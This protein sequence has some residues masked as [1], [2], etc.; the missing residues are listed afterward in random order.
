V[1]TRPTEAI[2]A[3]VT[4]ATGAAILALHQRTI[5]Q[6]TLTSAW[7]WSWAALAGW[8]GVELLAAW[9]SDLTALAL[10]P[11]RL[12]AVALSFCPAV[13]L[14]GAKRPQHA[15]WNIVVVSLWGIVALPAA[16]NYFLHPGQRLALGD[17]RGWFLWILILLGPI[18]FLPTRFWLA[19]L[20]VAVGQVVALSRYVA[21]PQ[22]PPVPQPELVGL[23][24]CGLGMLSAAA[25]AR[26]KTIAANP[27]DRLW[28]D[29][30]NSFGLFWSLRVQERM[31]AASAQH[32]WDVELG[33][34]GFRRREEAL[35]PEAQAKEPSDSPSLALQS[36]EPA[37]RT[38]F[39]GLLRRFVSGEW[40]AERM[41]QSLD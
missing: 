12:A 1:P 27:L 15:A 16:E 18:N 8:A 23:A 29:F 32:G 2:V 6:T 17:A 3:A 21:L 35:K 33:W 26:R 36:S 20:L 39:K 11:L 13:S 7:C 34:R 22:R 5:R 19:A 24:L 4:L 28:L 41:G 38:T 10:A 31:N 37:L 9:R 30:R 14:V 40:I 25:S